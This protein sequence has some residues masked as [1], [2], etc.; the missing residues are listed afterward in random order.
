MNKPTENLCAC[1][2]PFKEHCAGGIFHSSYKD[3]MR[4]VPN[5]RGAKCV[6]THCESVLCCCT[7]FRPAVPPSGGA[8]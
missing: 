3:A 1:S 2:H 8:A 6:S 7:V 4:Q 5:P